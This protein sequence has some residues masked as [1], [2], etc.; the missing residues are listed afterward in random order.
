MVREPAKSGTATS[1]VL[2]H[3]GHHES[4][5]AGHA[6]RVYFEPLHIER[7]GVHTRQLTGH[8]SLVARE[9]S[10][11]SVDLSRTY[12][13]D[14]PRRAQLEKLVR[15]PGVREAIEKACRESFEASSGESME[16]GGWIVRDDVT[17]ALGYEPSRSAVRGKDHVDGLVGDLPRLADEGK[18]VLA[19]FHTHLN[20]RSDGFDVIQSP[21]DVRTARVLGVPGIVGTRHGMVYFDGDSAPGRKQ[22]GFFGPDRQAGVSVE[23]RIREALGQWLIAAIRGLHEFVEKLPRW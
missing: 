7:D 17:G 9:R 23:S 22:R 14:T 6:G 4:T 19:L 8:A 1:V 18:T 5:R 21:E 20:Q 10:R 12:H 3:A 15:T 16:Q 13:A 11:A 2:S